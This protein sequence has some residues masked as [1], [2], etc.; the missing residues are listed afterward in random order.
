LETLL[1]EGVIEVLKFLTFYKGKKKMVNNLHQLLRSLCF[2]TQWNY[3]IFWK[4][5]HCAPMYVIT[6]TFTPF[7]VCITCIESFIWMLAK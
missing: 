2:N 7:F 4:L 6:T 3:A 1:L 5:K